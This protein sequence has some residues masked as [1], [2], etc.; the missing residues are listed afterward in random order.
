MA[1]A[2][3]IV[4]IQRDYFP[5]GLME[6][7]GADAA[8][9][10]A[11]ALLAAAR[12]AGLKVIH[13]QHLSNRPGASFFLPGTP[14]AEIH[15]C[16]APKHGESVITKHFPSAFRDTV[17]HPLLRELSITRLVVCGMMTQMCIDTTVRA[18][19]DLGYE[20]L[21]AHD[22]CAT[23]ALSFGGVDVPAPQVQAAIMAALAAVFAT[24]LP[25]NELIANVH[26]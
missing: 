18:A 8:G 20:C 23:R 26:A 22:A 12:S 13:I 19:F 1:T 11:A 24:V 4:D 15:P 21:V 17:L 14:G 16:V 25:T 10:N 9:K 2:L 6:L 7:E 5:G 3:I